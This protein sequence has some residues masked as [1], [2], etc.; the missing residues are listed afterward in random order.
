[1][2]VPL[3]LMLAACSSNPTAARHPSDT[4][5]GALSPTAPAQA[6]HRANARP[7]DAISRSRTVHAAFSADLDR[8]VAES[9]HLARRLDLGGDAFDISL[10]GLLLT[11]PE[12]LPA[13][14]AVLVV[15]P[16]RSSE[17]RS[18]PTLLK[19]MREL[20]QSELAQMLDR[21]DVLVVAGLPSTSATTY[22]SADLEHDHLRLDTPEARALAALSREHDPAVVVELRDLP[23]SAPTRYELEPTTDPAAAKFITRAAKEWFSDPLARE[24]SPGEAPQ[25]QATAF[26]ASVPQVAALE[27][28]VSLRVAIRPDAADDG[29]ALQALSGI[30]RLAAKRAEDV[31]KLRHYVRA[32]VASQA[33]HGDVHLDTQRTLPRPCGYWLAESAA[34]AVDRLRML[35]VD[36]VRLD[37]AASVLGS[38]YQPQAT[39]NGIGLMDALIDMP[40]GSY[41]VSMAQARAN[42]IPAVLEPDSLQG[43]YRQQIIPDAA[44][45]ARL[46]APLDVG[47]GEHAAPDETQ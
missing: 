16:A 33:C 12:G 20:T 43:Y 10:Q 31:E 37:S 32:E 42:V 4:S 17:S 19:L 6:I 25:S 7:A 1:M 29:V 28:A 3:A 36:V 46:R 44:L 47:V 26:T 13:K 9:N 39:G 24:L 41:Y 30:L 35:G 23:L 34:A 18:A 45:I 14:P 2:S 22:P 21:I 5:A 8:L 27:N 40:P 11:R 15:A 38:V